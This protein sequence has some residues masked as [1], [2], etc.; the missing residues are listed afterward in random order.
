MS[1]GRC[2]PVAVALALGAGVPRGEAAA[3]D[4]A[5]APRR[6]PRELVIEIPGERSRANAIALA[7][8]AGAGVLA[9]AAGLYFHLDA[10]SVGEGVEADRFTGRVW[11]QAQA[12]LV[13]RAER[14]SAVAAVCYGAGGALVLGAAI[15]YIVTEP[16]S[17]TSVIRTTHAIP[18]VAPVPGGAVLGGAW[19]F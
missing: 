6:R 10:R 17:E 5:P 18:A 3:D 2:W 9:G 19:R 12:D 7:A 14:S 13:A 11:T 16:R 15:A 4:V 8:V 1:A